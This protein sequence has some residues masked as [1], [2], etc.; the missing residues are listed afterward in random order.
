V[1]TNPKKHNSQNSI[2]CVLANA[3]RQIRL[4]LE[5]NGIF[6]VFLG[7]DGVGKSTLIKCLTQL[8]GPAFRY[9]RVFHWRPMLL[10][11]REHRHE[12]TDPHGRPQHSTWWS[13]GRLF[14]HLLDYWLG[15]WLV[16]RPLVA[17]SG[18]VIFDRYFYDLLVDPNRYRY[19]GPMWAARFLR[20]FIPKPDL[21]FVLDASEDVVLSRKQE[22]TAEEIRRQRRAYQR[23]TNCFPFTRVIDTSGPMPEVSGK[24]AHYITNYLDRR[25]Q[26]RNAH[27]ASG[28]RKNKPRL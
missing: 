7:P 11:P 8:I 10:W 26:L 21:L 1:A 18:L 15:Y 19:G 23:E 25:F 28:S 3:R 16:I 13:I 6:V 24:L 22:I 14:A 27:W 5:P 2:Q 12:A 17:R 4:W 20:G 9:D